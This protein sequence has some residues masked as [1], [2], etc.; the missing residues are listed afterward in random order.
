M[1]QRTRRL[2]AD[3]R[4][5]LLKAALKLATKH[6]YRNVTRAM[7][8]E[9]CSVAESLIPYYFGTMT[10][11]HRTLMRHA[12]HEGNATV[13]AQ[14]LADGNTYARKAPDALRKAAVAELVS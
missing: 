7:V 14:G 5:E 2:P 6:G 9:A 3:R 11:F 10:Q 13:V 4:E 1:K 8:A 12:I